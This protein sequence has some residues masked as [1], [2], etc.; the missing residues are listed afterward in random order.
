L[1][2]ERRGP[3]RSVTGYSISAVAESYDVH[4][5]TLRLYER[6]GLLNPFRSAG[7]TRYYSDSDLERLEMILTL[8]RDM[9]VNLAGVDVIIN[10]RERLERM[11]EDMTQV[12]EAVR[13]EIAVRF[14]DASRSNTMA[15]VLSTRA[16]PAS[17]VRNP[18]RRPGSGA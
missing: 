11:Q 2:E 4:P 17:G 8:T 12:L 3:K 16:T 14:A 6:A 9:G 5:Q 13:G 7:N 18:R 10:L 15:L 1:S